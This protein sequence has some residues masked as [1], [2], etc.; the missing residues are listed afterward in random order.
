MGLLYPS[1]FAETSKSHTQPAPHLRLPSP[2]P[3]VYLPPPATP[4][5]PLPL[6]LS[7]PPRRDESEPSEPPT[8]SE[9]TIGGSFGEGSIGEGSIGSS[10]FSRE[11]RQMLQRLAASRAKAQRTE[12]AEALP[13]PGARLDGTNKGHRLLTAMGWKGGALGRTGDA[14]ERSVAEMLPVQHTR[15]GLGSRRDAR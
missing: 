12:D 6:I 7:P 3:C 13:I 8:P 5:L 1:G 10:E 4:T 14:E 11:E 9:G 2:S 15:R